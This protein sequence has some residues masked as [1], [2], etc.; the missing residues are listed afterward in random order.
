MAPR[1][2]SDIF[3][4]FL[5]KYEMPK[6]SKLGEVLGLKLITYSLQRFKIAVIR[7]LGFSPLS[8]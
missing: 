3:E 1:I 4:R 2:P 5:K 7:R 6:K 8:E